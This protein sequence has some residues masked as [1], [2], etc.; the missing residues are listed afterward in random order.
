[1]DSPKVILYYCFTPLSDP[2]AIHLWQRE[3]CEPLGLK[4]RILISTHGIN[5]TLGG[6]MEAI[7][8]YIKHTRRYHGFRAMEFKWSEGRGDDFPRLRVRVRDEIVT[9]GAAG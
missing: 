2:D 3:L 6:P 9:F 7:K 8:T 5:G 4:G 1:M